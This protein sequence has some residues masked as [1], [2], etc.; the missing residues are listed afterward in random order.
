MAKTINELLST[1]RSD[2][3]DPLDESNSDVDCRWK[4]ATLIDYMDRAQREACIRSELLIDKTTAS[5]CI[6]NLKVGQRDYPL[7]KRILWIKS[8][9]ISG[10]RY[11]LEHRT[12]AELYERDPNWHTRQGMSESFITDE[13]E[14]V[15]T[16]SREPLADT[17]LGL[18]VQREPKNTITVDD[19]ESF[20]EIPPHDHLPMLDWVYH[21]AYNRH[22]EDTYNEGRASDHAAKF[23]AFFGQR[24]TAQRLNHKRRK[25]RASRSRAH[26]F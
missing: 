16:L 11:P 23:T 4:T 19:G 3:D 15:L 8:A 22:D 25:S 1:V 12:S 18:T 24:P 17:T 6:L 21:L 13:E 10:Q 2:L 14:Y 20:L 5:I 7:D 9:R 26:W